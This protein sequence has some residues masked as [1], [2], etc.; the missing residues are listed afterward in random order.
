VRG[1][2]GTVWLLSGGL[3]ALTLTAFLPALFCRFVTLDDIEYVRHNPNVLGGLS[4]AGAEW[5]FTTY[6]CRNWH[7]LT[8]LSLQLDAT[9]FGPGPLGFH[10]TNVLFHAANV[11]LLFLVLRAMTGQEM[12][13]AVVAALWAAHPLRV[14]SVAWVSERK[15]VL[16]VFFGLLAMAAYVRSA[17]RGRLGWYL[18]ALL[19]FLASLL[20]K[21]MLVTLPCLLLVLDFWPLCRGVWTAAGQAAG[22]VAPPFRPVPFP[23]LIAEKLP[24]LALVLLLLPLTLSAQF[25]ALS[26]LDSLPLGA[27][28]GNALL[29]YVRYLGLLFWPAG[30]TIEYPHP[31]RGLPALPVLLATAVV[32]CLTFL[33][34]RCRRTR[35]YLLV[36]WLWYLGTLV[37][38]IGL[39]QVG[40][41][42]LADRYT[43]FP[44][45]GILLALVWGAGD[46]L[47]ESPRAAKFAAVALTAVLLALTVTTGRQIRHWHD[48]LAL[49]RHAVEVNPS[50]PEMH[51]GLGQALLLHN[52][53][54]EA[55]VALEEA[56]R[57]DGDNPRWR[58]LLA[59]CYRRL[60][61]EEDARVQEAEVH[62][63][64]YGNAP[65]NP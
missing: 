8:W 25:V 17:R 37:P 6:A 26:D 3:L 19:A 2:C 42:G 64:S 18:A 31:G 7:P 15:D 43:Y 21:P 50:N 16:S 12:R 40:Q 54:P 23:R 61:R 36:G 57:L 38:V 48:G 9:L 32:A 5:A 58:R 45:V 29:S 53:L 34:L 47:A 4:R 35:P 51:A 55:A 13:S 39:V 41:Q 24:L 11:L 28:V 20:A 1:R 49:Y 62:R 59:F 33:A 52:A 63:L 10:L 60:G 56:V 46:L 44:T 22:A 30:L 27:R 14:E 65:G